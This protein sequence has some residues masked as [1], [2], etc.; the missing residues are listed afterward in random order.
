MSNGIDDQL[1]DVCDYQGMGYSPLVS[2]GEWRVAVLRYL[3]KLEPTRIDSM[4]RHI[5]T[6]EVFILVRGK[7]ILILGGNDKTI[8]CLSSHELEIG[9]VYNV[10]KNTWHT[11]SLSPD[12]HIIIVENADTGTENSKYCSLSPDLQQAVQKLAVEFFAS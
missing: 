12:A 1:I 8:D 7:A 3:E 4:E 11:L 2:Y 10:R 5:E 6:D 9:K